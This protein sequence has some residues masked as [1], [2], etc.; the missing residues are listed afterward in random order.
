MRINLPN[1]NHYRTNFEQAGVK[2]PLAKTISEP[3][4]ILTLLP[5]TTT[6][7]QGWPWNEQVEPTIYSKNIVWPKLTIVTPS[8]NQVEFLE[9]TIRSVL[10]QNYPN[11]EYIIIDGGS[12]DGS[13]A[14]L[15]KYSPWLSHWQSEK[16]N[17]Q[18]NAINLGFSLSSGNYHAWINSDDYYLKNVFHVVMSKFLTTKT[19]FIYG[20]IFNF[21]TL[22]QQLELISPWLISDYF[23]RIPTLGQPSCFWSK[24]IHQPIWEALSCSLDYELWL[25]MLKGKKRK[26]IRVPLSVANGHVDAKTHDP[27]MK[28]AWENDHRLICSEDAHGPVRNWDKI[29]LLNRV[30]QKL[31]KYFRFKR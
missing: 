30:F 27:K 2:L 7:N 16:D 5:Q 12:T 8:Y 26:I 13:K 14:I 31:G 17:G 22:N 4:G 24:E 19:E 9:Q 25:R 3:S 15:E 28:T 29:V 20:Y 18:G 21:D 10:L 11:L 23:I 1:L 6:K